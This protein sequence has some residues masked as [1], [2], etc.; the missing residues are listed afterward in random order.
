M[1]SFVAWSAVFL[2]LAGAVVAQETKKMTAHVMVNAADIKWGEA[3]AKLEKG[4]SFAVIS[5]DPSQSGPYVVRLKMPAGYKIAPHWHPTDENV[6]VLSGTFALGMGEKFDQAALKELPAGG[7]GLLP[8][9]MRHFAMAKTEAT[10]Q[11]HGMGPFVL[12][13]VNPADDPSTRAT[14]AKPTTK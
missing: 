11:V 3:P 4:A 8:A 6:T 2:V 12:T 1:R 5:G 9:E 14:T 10:V 7:F 13:Y